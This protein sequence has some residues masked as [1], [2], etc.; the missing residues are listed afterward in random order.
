M[1]VMFV[2]N[3]FLSLSLSINGQTM[4]GQSRMGPIRN[5]VL[6]GVH[7]GATWRLRLNDLCSAIR[8]SFGLL[9]STAAMGYSDD[10][11]H[12]CRL[13]CHTPG[14]VAIRTTS[15]KREKRY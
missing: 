11:R 10:G 12:A 15:A 6:D 4:L 7:I 5:L 2:A 13:Q 9:Q 3:K 8:Y 1:N 14:P